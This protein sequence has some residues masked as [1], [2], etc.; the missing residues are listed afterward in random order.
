MQA[1]LAGL[2]DLI[3]VKTTA[4]SAA[5]PGSKEQIGKVIADLRSKK[6][7]LEKQKEDIWAKIKRE[8]AK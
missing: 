8:T 2:T 5:K 1:Q 7:K 4:H 6:A 3:G